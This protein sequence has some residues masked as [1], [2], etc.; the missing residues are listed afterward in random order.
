MC[1]NCDNRIGIDEQIYTDIQLAIAEDV[2]P[3]EGIRVSII[4]IDFISSA[5][6]LKRHYCNI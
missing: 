5:E 3:Y 2:L 4:H 6:E 1:T